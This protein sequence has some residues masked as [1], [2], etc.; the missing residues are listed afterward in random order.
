MEALD[1][2]A[3]VN[4]DVQFAPTDLEENG[5]LERV[6]GMKSVVSMS[7]AAMVG[8]VL[9]LPGPAIA[10]TGASASLCVLT[11]SFIVLAAAS[12]KC[13]IATAM[14]ISGGAYVYLAKAFG[15]LVGTMAGFSL[16]FTLLFKGA[17][18][19][20]GFN[21]HLEAMIG[22]DVNPW[23]VKAI[24]LAL[25]GVMLA[26]NIAGL[27]KIK[28]YQKLVTLLSLVVVF[29]VSMIGFKD[30]EPYAFNNHFLERGST[31]FIESLA[32]V[33]MGYAGLTKIC[34]LASEIKEPEKNMPRSIWC[35][36]AIFTP[37]FCIGVVS[38]L[39]NIDYEDLKTD[40]APFVTLAI[41]VGGKPLGYLVGTLG[42][43]AMASMANVSLMAVSRFPFAMARDGLIPPAFAKTNKAGAPYSSLILS[44][45][46]MGL[47]IIF[48]PVNRIAKLCSAVILIVFL[49]I[50]V[51]LIVFR[52]HDEY[53]YKPTFISPYFPY[54]QLSGITFKFVMLIYIGVEGVVA[55]AGLTLLG[56][57]LYAFY[58]QHHAQFIGIIR[59]EKIFGMVPDHP[60]PIKE[61]DSRSHKHPTCERDFEKEIWE[62]E[63]DKG[64]P[65]EKHITQ[66]QQMEVEN[67]DLKKANERLQTEVDKYKAII[68]QMK[69]GQPDT[70]PAEAGSTPAKRGKAE[71][72]VVQTPSP[73]PPTLHD[74]EQPPQPTTDQEMAEQQA[75]EG[76][77]IARTPTL[78]LDVV[79]S[80]DDET[81]ALM[82][83]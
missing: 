67:L 69:G 80:I 54:L 56:F 2:V 16:W 60:E 35:S 33:F 47:A 70:S 65:H 14:P 45:A 74:A 38:C 73:Q 32:F 82:N 40:Y 36:L 25:L 44:A 66:I 5:D 75:Q 13:E 77:M 63:E 52:I 78:L 53:W 9:V 21:A 6:L 39:G 3:E 22:G 62:F 12:D 79:D 15:P 27:K 72:R 31:G 1:E 57:L 51:S 29:I 7:L 19:L 76:Q 41:A 34:A 55:A 46:L 61:H 11:G 50:N 28:F 43:L 8:S 24:G 18:G 68:A 83:K 64:L 17:F 26:G 71:G 58:G 49:F 42:I 10:L 59:V 81:T 23:A 48:L 30:W 37:F 20:A 4:K